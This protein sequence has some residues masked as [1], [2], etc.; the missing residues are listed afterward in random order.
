MATLAVSM[1]INLY[2]TS[3]CAASVRAPS[4]HAT[5]LRAPP[6]RARRLPA[7]RLPIAVKEHAAPEVLSDGCCVTRG[8][9]YLV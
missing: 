1:S 7:R 2:T 8:A 6:P 5:S 4:P 9:I 3:A